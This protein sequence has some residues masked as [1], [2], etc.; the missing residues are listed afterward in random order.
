VKVNAL[1][2]CTA[3]GTQSGHLWA[4]GYTIAYDAGK[5]LHAAAPPVRAAKPREP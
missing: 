5:A 2:H 3:P 4:S 1:A